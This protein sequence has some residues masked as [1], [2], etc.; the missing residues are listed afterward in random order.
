VRAGGTFTCPEGLAPSTGS[1]IAPL[2]PEV[3]SSRGFE[4]DGICYSK[5]SFSLVSSRDGS[6]T[7]NRK[8]L[9]FTE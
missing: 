2:Y 9:Y 8:S 6:V 3:T 7:V 1:S 5:Y 4:L